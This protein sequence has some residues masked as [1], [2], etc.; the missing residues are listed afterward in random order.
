MQDLAS[1]HSFI[2]GGGEMGALI[3]SMDWSK[4]PL[5]PVEDWPQSLKTTVSL[6]LSS[7]FPI[8]IAWGP[9]LIQIYNDSYRPICGAKH[10]ESM[11]QNFKICWETALPVVGGAFDRG[12]AGEGTYIKDQQMLLDRYGYLEEAFMT[13]SFAPIRDESGNVGGIFHP[14]TET[15]EQILSARRTQVLR[16]VAVH[17]GKART[18]SEVVRELTTIHP[19]LTYDLPFIQL[20]ELDSKTGLATLQMSSGT[21]QGALEFPQIDTQTS[22]ET[23]WPFDLVLESQDFVLVSNLEERFGSFQSGPFEQ[24]PHTAFIFPIQIA[25]QEKPYGFMVAGVSRG[26]ALDQEYQNFFELLSNAISTAFS[27]V[28]AYQQQQKRAQQLAEIDKAKTAFFSNVSHEFRTPLTLL[29][30]PLE[31]QIEKS[32][33]TLTML[34]IESMHRNALRLLK[35]VNNLLD[36]SRVEAGRVKASFEKVDL[37]EVTEDLASTFRSVMESA[38]LELQVRRPAEVMP[39][40]VDRDMWEKI[41]LNLLSNAFKYTLQGRV[42]VSVF[43]KDGQAVVQVADT[44]VGIEEKE[45]PHMFERFHRV[46]NSQG[47][48]HEGTGIGLSLVYELVNL[49]HGQ[50]QIASVFGEGTTFTVSIPTGKDHL[51]IE[52]LSEGKNLPKVVSQKQTFIL[53]AMSLLGTQN[54]AEQSWESTSAS[55]QIQDEPFDNSQIEPIAVQKHIH[56][57]IVDDNADM[58]QYLQRMLL[59]YFSLEFATNGQE[60]ID[61]I[62]IRTPDLIVSDIMMPVMDGREMLQQIRLRSGYQ[63]PVILLSARAGQESRLEGMDWGA[64]DYLVKPFSAKELLT[65]VSALIKIHQGRKK[66]EEELRSIFRQAPVAIGIFRGQDLIIEVA[67]TMLLN[68]WNKTSEQVIGLPYLSAFTEISDDGFETMVREVLQSGI[69]RVVDQWPVEIKR[70]DTLEKLY[71]TLALEPLQEHNGIVTK[72]MMVASNVTE[73]STALEQIRESE[74]RFRLLANSMPLLVWS[75]DTESNNHFYNAFA[76]TYFGHLEQSLTQYM[77]LDL[78]HPDEK[79][80]S[81]M[82]WKYSLQTGKDFIY[83]HRYQRYD[84]EYR[85]HLTRGTALRGRHGQM[86]SWIMTSTDIHDQ[87]TVEEILEDRVAIRTFELKNIN[88]QLIKTNAELEQFAY[89]ASHDLQEPLR[90][91]QVFTKLIRK[92]LSL[93]DEESQVYADRVIASANRMSQLVNDILKYSKVAHIELTFEQTDLNTI[94]QEVLADFELLIAE[95]EAVVSVDPLPV[96]E[97]VPLQMNQLF[98]NLLG[99]ALKFTRQKPTVEIQYHY[100][101]E[102]DAEVYGFLQT[103]I[104]YAHIVLIDNGIGFDSEHAERIFTIFQ[105]LNPDAGFEGNGIGLTICKRIVENHCGHIRASGVEN[106]G[107]VFEIFLPITK[108]SILSGI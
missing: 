33:N 18:N 107:A 98:Y 40:Y 54:A 52:Q 14:I 39:V 8:L 60:A 24:P 48:T 70:A 93:E 76:H 88:E 73:L 42:T 87:K 45:L 36:F 15:T 78:V 50:I 4:T 92:R 9:E 105:R 56:V 101:A 30:G 44:G 43:E 41:V 103:D 69:G 91:I 65:K 37:G 25:G 83:E 1:S 81:M 75:L 104:A 79:E 10:P 108:T 106:E 71:I 102:E 100:I 97:A 84:G 6:C 29:L 95:K 85:W 67:N 35:L 31:E 74:Q 63:I 34:D 57:L 51:S 32:R 12:L 64:D 90:K 99:N 38:G 53:E 58:R 2:S 7:T 47:R 3:R 46:E 96:I 66:T 61:K 62:E 49:H 13:F 59:P 23:H 94:V 21:S 20:Y 86:D 26:R 19:S 17:I 72:V 16:D 22:D 27:S 80:E 11:G 55:D 77:L 5:G 89:I 82:H 68:Y 28:D